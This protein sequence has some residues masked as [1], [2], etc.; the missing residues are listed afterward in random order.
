MTNEFLTTEELCGFTE[1]GFEDELWGAIPGY[2]NYY[3][4]TE[5]RVWSV[6]S[7]KILKTS[8]ND[9]GYPMVWLYSNER[10]KNVKISR[11]EALTFIPNPDNLPVVRHLNDIKTDNR[12][13]NLAW[14]SYHDNAEDAKKNGRWNNMLRPVIMI[15]NDTGIGYY[16]DSCYEASRDLGYSI[17]SVNSSLI[18]NYNIGG[19]RIEDAK[20][21]YLYDGIRNG[22]PVKHLFP[23]RK[24]KQ[25]PKQSTKVLCTRCSDGEELIFDNV[26]EVVKFFDSPYGTIRTAIWGKHKHK[27]YYIEYID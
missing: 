2:E 13:E 19:Y 21:E 9:N 17:S 8:I 18:Q 3:V 27:G 24:M 16:Y 7:G 1:E 22:Y 26:I 6:D 25:R 4:S 23:T 14:G 20:E 5:G 10:C 15:N 11:I 12:L